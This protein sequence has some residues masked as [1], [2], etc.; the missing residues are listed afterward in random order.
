MRNGIRRT[1]GNVDVLQK[2]SK[3]NIKLL[4]LVDIDE[5][6]LLRVKLENQLFNDIVQ[7]HLPE[8]YELVTYRDAAIFDYSARYCSLAKYIFKTDD[9]VFINS[10]LLAKFVSQLNR[11]KR[12]STIVKCSNDLFNDEPLVMYGHPIYNSVVFRDTNHPVNK[13]Y[14][15]TLNEY[16]CNMYPTFLSGFGYLVPAN[17]RSLLLCT[18]YRDPKPFHLSDVYFTALLG[19][20]LNIRREQMSN[21]NYRI[22]EGCKR[23]LSKQDSI[24]CGTGSHFNDNSDDL[25]NNYNLYWTKIMENNKLL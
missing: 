20:Y 8:Y 5:M 6:R 16:K 4:F 9:D 11:T 23:F 14:V 18:F 22:D 12:E 3:L 25:M 2:Y 10:L 19:E 13:R 17:V 15:V 21:F 7:V 1:W 24:A